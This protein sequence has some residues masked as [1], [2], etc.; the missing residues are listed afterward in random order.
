MANG[1]DA[2]NEGMDLVS[3]SA[4]RSL[5]YDEINKTRDYIAE[6]FNTVKTWATSLFVPKS[7]VVVSDGASSVVGKIPRY[8]NAARLIASNPAQASDVA[9]KAYVDAQAGGAITAAGGTINGGNLR[10]TG[11]G[12]HLYVTAATSAT[13]GYT[14]AYING[15]GRLAEGASSERFKH[16][17]TPIDPASLGNLFPTLH[18]FVMN[19]DPGEMKRIGY[20]AERLNESDDLRQFVVY[21][22]ETITEDII[23][24]VQ[25]LEDIPVLDEEGQEVGTQ[26]VQTGTRAEVVGSRVIGSRL[27]RDDNGDP[28]PRSIDFIALLMAQ[29]AQ[30]HARLAA[31]EAGRD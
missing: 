15:D 29:N 28:I 25:V 21:E 31:L 3:G 17:I 14:V 7:D 22:R 10:I 16:N 19:E 26:T 5:G 12:H 20:I 27:V 4:S 18:T 8:T 9:T 24:Q 2:A 13:S 6:F 30:L 1:D 23:E 11:S